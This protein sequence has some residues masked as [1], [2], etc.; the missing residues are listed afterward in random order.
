MNN[1]GNR[2][3]ELIDYLKLSEAEFAKKIGMAHPNL[4][5]YLNNDFGIGK[6]V[7]NKIIEI[8]NRVNVNWLLNGQ[9]E[10]LIQY[11]DNNKSEHITKFPIYSH[12]Y[13]GS[14]ASQWNVND[15]I[16][17]YE[18]PKLD[19]KREPFG[20]IAK[21]DSMMP[22]INPQDLIVCVDDENLIKPRTAVVVVFKSVETIE[23]NAKLIKFKEKNLR[24]NKE[25]LLYSI[26][27][28]YEP[29]VYSVKEILRIYKVVR[30]VR[31]VK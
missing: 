26:N 24:D 6:K 30:V 27:T 20:L 19:K 3:K 14:P 22:F 15:V 9:G 21:G 12:V 7:A 28:K 1:S 31:E 11:V 23:A 10:M 2:L 5:K 8:Y 16:D 25:V 18:L 29:E 4:K 17:Y 13:C